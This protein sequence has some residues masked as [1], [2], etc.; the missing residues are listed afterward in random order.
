MHQKRTVHNGPSNTCSVS[1]S[2]YDDSQT[3]SQEPLISNNGLRL[4]AAES[5]DSITPDAAESDG[6]DMEGTP[7]PL[8]YDHWRHQ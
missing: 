5:E 7:G 1:Q 2:A 4:Y 8:G 6:A 3:D